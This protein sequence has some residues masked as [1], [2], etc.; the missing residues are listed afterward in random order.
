MNLQQT[1]EHLPLNITVDNLANVK[2]IIFCDNKEK[3]C[4][5]LK[6]SQGGITLHTNYYVGV[7]WLKKNDTAIYVAPK[8]NEETKETDYFQMLFSCMKHSDISAYSKDLYEIKFDEPYIE[9]NQKQDL[10][11]PLLM[12]RYLQVLKSVVRKGLKKSYYRVEQNLSSKIKGKVLVSKTLKQNIL[13]NRP[14][15]TI[16]NFEVYGVD[17][18]ENK[19]LKS[20]LKFAE[21]YLAKYR[22]FSDYFLPLIS[23]CKPAFHEVDDKNF[24]LHLTK[25]TKINAFYKEYKEALD[26]ARMIIKRFGYNLKEIDDKV[27][28][29]PPFWIDMP[30]LFE[31]YVLGL[32]KEK[33]GKKIH[34]QEKA[35]YGEP[36]FLLITESEKIV[37]D[38]KYKQLY[39]DNEKNRGRY[40][41]DD[42]RQI[43]GYARDKKILKCF[44]YSGEEMENIVVDCLI[45]YPDQR[46]FEQ[47]PKLLK[48]QPIDQFIKFY[49]MP[50]KLPT[51]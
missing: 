9:I 15:K 12:I 2:E 51:L 20:A 17:S 41:S 28:S 46:S 50:I 24:D 14:N 23:F 43:A 32:L 8:L 42:I 18:I 30:K 40:N 19:I 4:I 26:L 6:F 21:M 3:K 10:I 22:Q 29:V 38:T 35:N 33:Y 16:C 11:T 25:Q 1:F 34:F 49:K 36:D 39:Q 13:K 45:I 31:L 37:I 48:A 47:L 27:V 44:G 5:E 7:D